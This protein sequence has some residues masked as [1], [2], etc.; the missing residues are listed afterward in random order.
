MRYLRAML[1]VIA[2][3]ALTGSHRP[4]VILQAASHPALTQSEALKIA[5]KPM[6][7][8]DKRNSQALDSQ[9]STDA[10]G[11]EPHN[12]SLIQGSAEW[13]KINKNLLALKVDGVH[14]RQRVIQILSND[15]FILTSVTDMTSKDGPVKS[16][17]WRCTD[18]F[19]RK[20][21]GAFK[22]INEHCSFPPAP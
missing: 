9:Y 17:N 14:L 11:F 3:V 8:W 10:I 6:V 1:S 20:S 2:L 21:G 12:A 4:V 7:D 13:L 5:T 19:Q 18:V 16:M 22:V 15:V